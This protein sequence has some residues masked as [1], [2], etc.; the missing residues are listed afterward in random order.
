MDGAELVLFMLKLEVGGLDVALEA[1]VG[2]GGVC[3]F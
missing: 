2:A 3:L 1:A